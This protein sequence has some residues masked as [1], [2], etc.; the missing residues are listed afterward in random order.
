MCPERGAKN[1]LDRC[2]RKRDKSAH[3]NDNLHLPDHYSLAHMLARPFSSPD[4]PR[5]QNAPASRATRIFGRLLGE[6]YG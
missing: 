1:D 4:I 5:A 6:T 3:E 2:K